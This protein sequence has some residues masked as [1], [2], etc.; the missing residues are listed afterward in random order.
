MA[1]E[2]LDK[3]GLTY[4]WSKLKDYFQVKL[5]SGTNIKTINNTRLLGSGNID[6]SGGGTAGEDY[7][8]E[9][10]TNGIWT[11]RKWESGVS[12]CWC[13][14]SGTVASYTSVFGG[15][16]YYKDINF[17]TG[18]FNVAPKPFFTA[19]VGTSFGLSAMV[20]P[21]SATS[22]RFFFVGSSSGSQS[23]TLHLYLIGT[24]K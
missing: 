15:Y 10:G 20:M 6:L 7:I 2:Y 17:P 18:M 5:V 4:F 8:V 19:K 13:T 9:Q 12:E 21:I 11:Y 3:T 23:V 16:G 24:W 1:K 22:G 14:W